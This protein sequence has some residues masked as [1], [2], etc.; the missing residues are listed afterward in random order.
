MSHAGL[1]GYLYAGVERDDPRIQSTLTWIRD[2][3]NL[4]R[5]NRNPEFDGQPE[6]L[7]G[8]YFM[9][10]LKARAMDAYGEETLRPADG[11]PINWRADL[12]QAITE[13][14]S[15]DGYWINPYGRYWENDPALTTA[16]ALLALQSAL[17]R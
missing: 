2:N 1:L 9:Y 3:W 17:G 8:L 15:E 14:Q 16:Y 4:S 10:L 5:G 7:G 13:R 6:A 12:I 11:S